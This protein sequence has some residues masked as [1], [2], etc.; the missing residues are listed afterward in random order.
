MNRTEQNEWSEQNKMTW[1]GSKV[2]TASSHKLLF[3][4]F[5]K[6]KNQDKCVKKIIAETC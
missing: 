4:V 2:I 5:A 1:W 3:P 6:S